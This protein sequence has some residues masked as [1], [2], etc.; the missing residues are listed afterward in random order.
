MRAD[1]PTPRETS[2]GPLQPPAGGRKDDW[3]P[4]PGTDHTATALPAGS[5]ATCGSAPGAMS[6]AGCQT[7]LV[8]GLVEA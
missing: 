7:P 2:A 8:A 4:P 3:M 1:D 6:T 5:S